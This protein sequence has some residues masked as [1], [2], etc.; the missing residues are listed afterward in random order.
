[1]AGR[2]DILVTNNLFINGY[3]YD[4]IASAHMRACSFVVFFFSGLTFIIR[5]SASKFGL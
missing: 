1:M 2:P 5:F 4:Y 3:E